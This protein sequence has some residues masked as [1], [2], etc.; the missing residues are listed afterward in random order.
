MKIQFVLNYGNFYGANRSILNVI[1]HFITNGHEVQ[2]LVPSVPVRKG[3]VDALKEKNIPYKVAPY[4]SA[5][6][7]YKRDFKHLVIPFL[8][9]LNIFVF[10]LL[11]FKVKKFNP[12]V[13]YSNTSAENLGVFIARI[14]GVKHVLH[15][16]EFMDKDYNLNFLFGPKAKRKFINMSDASVYVSKS[17]LEGVQGAM[18]DKAR[19][20]V[21]YNGLEYTHKILAEKKLN[22]KHLIFGIVGAIDPAKGQYEAILHFKELLR[23]YPHASLRIYGDKD[24]AYKVKIINLIEEMDLQENVKIMGFEP[25]IE[26]IYNTIDILLM[27]S[28]SEGFGRVTVE[29]AFRGVPVIGYNNAGTSEII[30]DRQTGCLFNDVGSFEKGVAFLLKESN[31]ETIRRNAF[32]NAWKLFSIGQCC[33]KIEEFV[34]EINSI[35]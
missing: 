14:L 8:V 20:K 17:V 7:Y 4:Y 19:H 26:R 27:F 23:T 28:K 5:F 18:V 15:I 11:V 3:M 10:P 24:S 31:Y 13:I 9:L 35:T 30:T 22:T 21:I 32:E 6:L 2:V 25:E 16:R 1:Q 33:S 29:A 12:D 34:T